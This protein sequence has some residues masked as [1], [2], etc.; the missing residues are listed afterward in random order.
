MT[1][2]EMRE[3]K[4]A[5]QSISRHLND[6]NLAL[7][8]KAFEQALTLAPDNAQLTLAYGNTLAML[9]N[10]EAASREFRKA[11]MLAPDYLDAHVGL[12]KCLSILGRTT[13]AKAALKEAF[14]IVGDSAEMRILAESLSVPYACD[15]FSNQDRAS[16]MLAGA[17]RP[18]FYLRITMELLDSQTN[19]FGAENWDDMRFGPYADNLPNNTDQ[20]FLSF[21]QGNIVRFEA[22]YNFLA[23]DYSRLLLIKLIAY[24]ILGFRKVKLPLSYGRDKQADIRFAESLLQS[25]R[26][27]RISFNNWELRHFSLHKVGIPMECYLRFPNRKNL[28]QY[29][30]SRHNPPI[31]VM[32]GDFVIDGGACWGDTALRFAHMAGDA[33]GIYSFEFE[34]ENLT[35]FSKNMAMNPHLAHR[36]TLSHKALWSSTGDTVRFASQGPGTRLSTDGDTLLSAPTMKLDDFVREHEI[37]RVD[38]IKMDIEGSELN[39]LKGAEQ[40]L[41]TFRPKLAICLY[42]NPSDFLTIPEFINS[43]G[44]SYEFFLDHI[45][46]H[47]EETV[48]FAKP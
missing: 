14:R 2:A 38:F 44:L 29:E 24:R 31:K 26:S 17:G 19:W 3:L 34:P 12:I 25:D 37:E 32:P 10:A 36:I 5:L 21:F 47:R 35:I 40:V 45:T 16:A 6:G 28:V 15:P 23:D 46:I 27:I 41:R 18:D 48:L 1:Q 9:G 22:F 42:H 30:Y 11:T 8:G 7:A 4:I 13:Q 33:G 43:L 39:A 20:D